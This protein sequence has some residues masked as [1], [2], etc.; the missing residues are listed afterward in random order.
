MEPKPMAMF[1]IINDR[2]KE[3]LEAI[4]ELLCDGQVGEAAVN[5]GEFLD[6]VLVIPTLVA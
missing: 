3:I 6:S 1:P 4:N 5:L 2:A